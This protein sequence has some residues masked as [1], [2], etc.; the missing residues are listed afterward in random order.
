MSCT[1]DRSRVSRP[2]SLFLI[3]VTACAF[4][5][6]AFITHKGLWAEEQAKSPKSNSP[7]IVKTIPTAGATDVDPKLP[8]ITVV[9]DRD[10]GEGMSWTG[11]PPLFP[12]L[13]KARQSKW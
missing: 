6:A 5:L 10:M 8:E 9:F 1:P 7:Q 3:G 11:G 13:D 12:P 4:A 2:C